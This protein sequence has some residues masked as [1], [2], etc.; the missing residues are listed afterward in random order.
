MTVS[1]AYLAAKQSGA[2]SFVFCYRVARRDGVVLGFTDHDE[3]LVFDGVTYRADAALSATEAE[4]ALGLGVD[5]V[6]TAGA[7]RS[8]AITE[9][10]LLAGVYDGAE[11]RAFEVDWGDVSVRQLLAVYDLGAIRRGAV[12]FQADLQSRS[13]RLEVPHGRF[14]GTCDAKL[15][16]ARC[17]V[18]LPTLTVGATAVSVGEDGR[19]VVTAAALGQATGYF[20]R[21]LLTWSSGAAAGEVLDV[22]THVAGD[23]FDVLELWRAPRGAAQAGDGLTLSP[24][25]DKAFATCGAKF[26]NAANYRGFPRLPREDFAARYAVRG[27]SDLD[28]GRAL[29]GS[30]A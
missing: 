21:G 30:P 8:D 26:G 18:D 29:G 24:G 4:A 20:A 15:G 2:T 23:G 27:D 3:D 12:G 10:D 7:L 5:D 13:A 19:R 11:V 25:C 22:K 9:A 14:L 16:D 1:A 28:G 6:E 17:G